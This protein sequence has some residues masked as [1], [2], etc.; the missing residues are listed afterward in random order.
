ME[1]ANVYLTHTRP[2]VSI[3]KAKLLWYILHM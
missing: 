1:F 3:D 2:R